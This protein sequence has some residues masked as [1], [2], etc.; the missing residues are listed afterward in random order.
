MDGDLFT[1]FDNLKIVEP[2]AILLF[3]FKNAPL[4]IIA[5]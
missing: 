5:L 2:F 3:S 4:G 1:I